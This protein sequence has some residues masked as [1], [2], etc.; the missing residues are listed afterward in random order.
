M[1]GKPGGDGWRRGNYV[2]FDGK[3]FWTSGQG[4]RVVVVVVVAAAAVAA[5]AVQRD[6]ETE[7]CL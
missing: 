3:V 1:G 2:R 5:A 4:S 7:S 6:R